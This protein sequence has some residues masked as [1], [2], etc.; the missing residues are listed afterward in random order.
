M[1][2]F[3]SYFPA[4]LFVNV[5][6]LVSQK[7]EKAISNDLSGREEKMGEWTECNGSLDGLIYGE[8]TSFL[9]YQF[10]ISY[11][12]NLRVREHSSLSLGG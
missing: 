7:S 12:Q 1:F 8:K 3:I 4:F 11:Q 9:V 6:V 5:K 10:G 2:H